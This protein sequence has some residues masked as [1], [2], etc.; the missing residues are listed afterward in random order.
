MNVS[1]REAEEALQA[2]QQITQKTRHSIASSGADLY[3]MATGAV[4]LVGFLATQFLSGTVVAVVWIV[5]SVLAG[6][7]AIL[8][9]MRR[10]K[11]V[12]APSASLNAQRAGLFWVLLL[13]YALAVILVVKP[14]DGRQQTM[15][16][17]LFMMLGQLSMGMLLSYRSVWWALPLTALAL[18]GYYWLP[19]IFYLWMGVLVG[20][21]M[22]VLGLTI[23][24]RW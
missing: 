9:G 23:R 14:L 20:G 17:V 19:G 12:R 24:L 1:P 6:L 10:S 8:A 4:W 18:I 22:I 3:L 5:A 15:L 2:I 16:V 13:A 21:S 11:R 7:T